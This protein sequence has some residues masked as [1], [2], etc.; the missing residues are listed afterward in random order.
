MDALRP[1]TAMFAGQFQVM[2]QYRAAAIAG[3]ATQCWWGALKV[4]ILAAFYLGHVGP[5]PMPLADAIDYTWLG[6]ALLALLPW[7]ADSTVAEAVRTGGVGCERLRPVDTYGLWFARAASSMLARALPRAPLMVA[8]A[9]V[10]LPLVGL[11]RW[12]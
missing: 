7:N 2:L 6:Q 12:G 9:G 5:T 10:V 8:L 4:M 1:Y 3:F 11:G